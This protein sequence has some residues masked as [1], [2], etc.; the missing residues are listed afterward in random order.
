MERQRHI[1]EIANAQIRYSNFSGR[2]KTA[3]TKDGRT[4]I[5]NEAGKR[6]F[7]VIIDPEK[8][9]IY[10]DGEQVTDPAFGQRLAE[11]NF[12]VSVKPA[13]EEYP[14]EY[15]LP[16]AIGFEGMKKPSLYLVTRT[17][18]VLLDEE[19]IG[20]LD[21]ADIIKADIVINNGSP[22]ELN[23]GRILVKAW[24]NEGYFTIAQSRFATDYDFSSQQ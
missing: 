20:E 19:T 24:C 3:R 10:F 17:G 9:D 23:D 6:N 7:V 11:L 15:R 1:I 14:E 22:Y 5:V 2:E 8:S 12:N 18:K 4:K 21:G 13:S 16:V